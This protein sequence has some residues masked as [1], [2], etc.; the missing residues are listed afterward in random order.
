MAS[1]RLEKLEAYFLSV[2]EGRRTGRGAALVRAWL[3]W[4]S[5]L[6]ASIVQCRLWLYRRGIF[7][8]HTLGCQVLS[9]G[10]L[11]VG[12]TGKTPVVEV[13]AR[14]LQ[15]KGR[16][17]AI[18]SRGYKRDKGPL[19][20]RVVNRL[21]GRDKKQP[22]L[23]VSD[24]KRLL[25]DASTGGDEPY[26]L[27]RNLPD[28]AVLVDANRVKAGQYA[29]QKLGCDTLVLDDGFQYVSLKH[30]LDV[31]L[32]DRTNPFGNRH[33]LPRGILRE[34]IRNVRRAGFI[35][36]T[37]SN[38]DGAAE[39][40]AQLR[41][42]NPDAEISECRHCARYLQDVYTGERKNLS[43]LKDLAVGAVSGIAVPKGFEDELIRLG[44]KVLYHKRYT[45]HHRYTQQ[46]ILDVLN[47]SISRGAQALIT[48]EKD[49]VRFPLVDRRDLPIYFLRVEIE[50]LSGTE[51]FNEW[52]SRICFR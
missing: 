43:M 44:A 5:Y 6:F 41:E 36:I 47:R 1:N 12:G 4:N 24:G 39:L 34:P 23:V 42:L 16:R 38:G 29:I 8:H 10:N 32:V 17:V 51:A 25:L 40:K 2:I 13:F 46:E 48:T 15:Q 19:L 3:K 50:M 28:V 35:F 11:T 20:S 26:M 14:S 52:I 22:P 31:V 49:A 27:A 45:D 9:V 37:K 18:L 33:L 7:R 30:W 21:L